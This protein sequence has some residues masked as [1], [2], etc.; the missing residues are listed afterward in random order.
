MA[1]GRLQRSGLAAP[2][3]SVHGTR[4]E[5]K[6]VAMRADLARPS[7]SL[8]VEGGWTAVL[9]LPGLKSDED[10]V[11]D[12]LEG[13]GVLVQPGFFYDFP[14]S[15]AHVVLSLLTPEPEFAAGVAKLTQSVTDLLR[16]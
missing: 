16:H 9:R 13:E 1:R 5:A 8:F 15:S 4:S 12:L 2:E 6:R 10:W 14:R 11:I 7:G 3:S